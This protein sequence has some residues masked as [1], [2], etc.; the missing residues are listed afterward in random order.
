MSNWDTV[1]QKIQI[2]TDFRHNVTDYI[3]KIYST[4]KKS[5]LPHDI[6]TKDVF[7]MLQELKWDSEQKFVVFFNF[8]FVMCLLKLGVS[9]SRITYIAPSRESF[10]EVRDNGWGKNG[11]KSI[12]FD[13]TTYN[14]YGKYKKWKRYIMK[15]IGNLNEFIGVGNIPFTINDTDSDNSKKV[16]NDFIKLMNQMKKACYIAPFKYHSKTFNE[17]LI[18]NKNLIKIVY[19]DRKLFNIAGDVY[20]CHVVLDTQN[21]TDEFIYRINTSSDVKILD[22]NKNI[23]LAKDL[24]FTTY[25]DSSKLTLGEIWTRGTTNDGDLKKNGKYKVVWKLIKDDG[26]NSN[27][28]YQYSDVETT[29]LGQWKVVVPKTGGIAAKLCSPDTSISYSIIGFPVK[30][31]ES[32]IKLLNYLRSTEVRELWKALKSNNDNTK[33]VFSKIPLPDGII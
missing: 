26:D 11:M 27:I 30:S 3:S 15:K 7:E 10:L 19:H 32:A 29:T 25:F 13:L 22:R 16:G 24:K 18:Y 4:R 8:E 12:L 21:P 17:E 31:K 23:S 1:E 5:I 28:E 14:R 2:D 6:N 33:A 20:T 9:S